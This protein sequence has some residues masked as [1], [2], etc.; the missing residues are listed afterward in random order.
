VPVG[1]LVAAV[2]AGWLAQV[3]VHTG[4]G[5]GVAPALA[6]VGFG[7]AAALTTAFSLGSAGTAASHAGVASA[8]V[9]SGNQIGG[10]L[11]AALLNTIATSGATTYLTSHASVS[12]AQ[13]AAAVHGDAL[14]FTVLAVILVAG[15]VTTSLIHRPVAR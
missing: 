13:T 4:Y 15:A 6:M 7:V 3:D 1:L 10:S 8:L 5:F 9:N 2:G 12:N 11:G 14:A